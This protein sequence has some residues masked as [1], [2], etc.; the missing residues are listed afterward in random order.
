MHPSPK[1]IKGKQKIRLHCMLIYEMLSIGAG[2]Q[3]P[4]QLPSVARD[5]VE[6]FRGRLLANCV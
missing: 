2:W 3:A 5:G 4:L 1:R 6:S